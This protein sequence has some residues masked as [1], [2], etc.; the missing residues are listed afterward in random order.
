MNREALLRSSV[1]LRMF[2][3]SALNFGKK[4]KKKIWNNCLDKLFR[5]VLLEIILDFTTSPKEGWLA[6]DWES[7]STCSQQ[8]KRFVTR[9]SQP[10]TW[11][12]RQSPHSLQFPQKN[13]WTTSSERKCWLSLKTDFS[14]L[15]FQIFC[16][17][18]THFYAFLKL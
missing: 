3:S 4:K 10:I 8:Q 5:L 1:L 6:I 2:W 17:L 7:S 11:A 13:S 16:S 15:L 18:L 9:W 12:I 14:D